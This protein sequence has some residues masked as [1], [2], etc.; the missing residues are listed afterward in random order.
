VLRRRSVFARAADRIDRIEAVVRAGVGERPAERRAVRCVDGADL[1]RR[2]R[3]VQQPRSGRPLVEVRHGAPAARS[4]H[5][6]VVK[7]DQLAGS[8]S[9]EQPLEHVPIGGEAVHAELVPEVSEDAVALFEQA[10]E[11]DERTGRAALDGPAP[12]A[13]GHVVLRGQARPRGLNRRFEEVVGTP[14]HGSQVRPDKEQ[15]LAVMG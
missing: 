15:V 3:D 10:P 9:E 13:H 14:A 2:F 4:G 11:V 7:F 8:V 1:R 12:K 6:V 5:Q